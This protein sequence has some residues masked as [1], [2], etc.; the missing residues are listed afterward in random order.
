M[1]RVRISN[2]L[3]MLN[4]FLAASTVRNI[5]QRPK[6]K[7]S[8]PAKNSKQPA[9]MNKD[10]YRIPACYP[11]HLWSIDLTEV[12]YWGLWKIYI[13]VAIDHF[14]RKVVSVIPLEGPTTGFAI[15]ALEAAFVKCGKPKH[16]ITDQGTVFTSAAFT[17]NNNLTLQA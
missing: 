17:E 4:I 5:L 13:L 6:P 15:N 2:Q 1:G 10:G 12:Y 3:K 8:S 16:I 9:G 11:N 7:N 14:S